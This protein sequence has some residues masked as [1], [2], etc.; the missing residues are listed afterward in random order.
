ME[1]TSLFRILYKTHEQAMHIHYKA[2]HLKT[3]GSMVPSVYQSSATTHPI[4]GLQAV[5]F[6]F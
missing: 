3:D 2:F 5:I 1:T 6:F 4:Y